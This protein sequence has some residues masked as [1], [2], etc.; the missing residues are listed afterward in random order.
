MNSDGTQA[1]AVLKSMFK[2]PE[3]SEVHIQCDVAQCAGGCSNDICPGDVLSAGLVGKQPTGD[4]TEDSTMLAATTVFVL[5]PADAP[6]MYSTNSNVFHVLDIV[7]I[8]S[9]S[10]LV[11]SRQSYRQYAKTLE[12]DRHGYCG[13]VSHWEFC[14]WSCYW[15]IFSCARQWAVVAPAL[16]WVTYCL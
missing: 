12:F 15:W 5:D 3:D 9:I 11:S 2:F 10:K 13:C 14:S 4:G 7:L 6:R 1:T 8:S 16:K